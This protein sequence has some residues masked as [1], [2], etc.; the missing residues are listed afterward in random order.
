M[1]QADLNNLFNEHCTGCYNFN[2]GYVNGRL[3]DRSSYNGTSINTS[4]LP[5]LKKDNDIAK[6]VGTFTGAEYMVIPPNM[7]TPEF[8][9]FCY[10]NASAANT[11]MI[12]VGCTQHGG[13]YLMICGNG[14]IRSLIYDSSYKSIET[15]TNPIFGSWHVVAANFSTNSWNM[16]VDGIPIMKVKHSYKVNYGTSSK[17]MVI[18]SEPGSGTSVDNTFRYVGSMAEVR[19]Y[20]KALDD[21]SILAVSREMMGLPIFQETI[22]VYKNRASMIQTVPLNSTQNILNK[23]NDFRE[24]LLGIAND[25]GNY[26]SLYVVG[27]DGKSHLT[28]N[29]ITA[30]ELW[31]GSTKT[32]TITLSE[33]LSNF[34]YIMVEVHSDLNSDKLT[35]CCVLMTENILI[36]EEFTINEYET[37]KVDFAFSKDNNDLG[38][39]SS[40]LNVV[41][42]TGIY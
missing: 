18:G 39:A 27:S 1:N 36:N 6:T 11:D 41:S 7:K 5:T 40:N 14:N 2:D 29:G 24:G 21:E 16:Y 38:V 34:K 10:L 13:T 22:N 31:N 35:T 19:F 23:V 17:S 15:P 33:N 30:K 3:A 4:H 25:K 9:Y 8:T 28:K 12:L 42:I 32:S 20:D 37:R 26:G